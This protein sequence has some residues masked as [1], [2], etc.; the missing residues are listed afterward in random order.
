MNNAR[1]WLAREVAIANEGYNH[2]HPSLFNRWAEGHAHLVVVL[3]HYAICAAFGVFMIATIIF[4]ITFC[5]PLWIWLVC[6]LNWPRTDAEI[7]L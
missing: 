1:K 3:I 2:G 6:Y 5:I 7:G 4:A